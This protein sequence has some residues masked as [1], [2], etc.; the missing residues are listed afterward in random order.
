VNITNK[1]QWLT[2]AS[3]FYSVVGHS[4]PYYNSRITC[5]I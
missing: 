3:Y 1:S 2:S 5:K 4:H